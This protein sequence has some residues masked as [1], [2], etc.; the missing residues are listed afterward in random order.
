MKNCK[1][2]PTDGQC[3]IMMISYEGLG[4]IEESIEPIFDQK[5]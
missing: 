4:H 3:V 1:I 2:C 5:P